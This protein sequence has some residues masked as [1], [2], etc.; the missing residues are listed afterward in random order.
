LVQLLIFAGIMLCLSGTGRYLY[1]RHHRLEAEFAQLQQRLHREIVN[2]GVNS[3]NRRY[4]V[5]LLTR[6]RGRANRSNVPFC[7]CIFSADH[8]ETLSAGTDESIKT[9]ALQAVELIIR[10]ELRDMDSLNSTGFHDCFGPY[11]D[12]EFIAVL[13]QT[14]LAGARLSAER[15]LAAI[16]AQ[17]DAADNHVELCGGIAEYCRRETISAL[18][19]RAE[20]ALSKARASGASSICGSGRDSERPERRNAA[21]VRLDTR[22]R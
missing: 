14:N 7:V 21:I 8:V 3:V 1:R 18:L 19:A 16:N 15:V 20:E 11:S 4:V 13:P 17:Q 2:T 10:A 12:R 5:D 6:E 9:R 22:R